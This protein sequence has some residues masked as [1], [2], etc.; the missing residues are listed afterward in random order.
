M[1]QGQGVHV[2]LGLRSAGRD[3]C[4]D[5]TRPPLSGLVHPR[6]C[7]GQA[8]VCPPAPAPLL[9]PRSLLSSSPTLRTLALTLVELAASFGREGRSLQQ[10]LL[11]V[12]V[13]VGTRAP[14]PQPRDDHVRFSPQSSGRRG[15]VSWRCGPSGSGNGTS[16]RPCGTCCGATPSS[17]R[18]P[19]PSASSSRRRWAPAAA[20]APA[21]CA[22][23]GG[24]HPSCFLSGL[25]AR[26]LCLPGGRGGP[27]DL[28]PP[29]GGWAVGGGARD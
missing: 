17:S 24:C 4:A 9:P 20:P 28:Q 25:G 26:L 10:S 23:E 5:V 3:L 2:Q 11:P 18:R 13:K 14:S 15:S 29:G 8:P 12:S 6:G 7:V 27:P 19:T 22:S 1:A 16:S 21:V